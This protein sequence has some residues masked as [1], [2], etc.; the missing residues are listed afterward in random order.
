MQ[1]TKL[2]DSDVPEWA[3]PHMEGAARVT[4]PTTAAIV[5]AP[6][7][8]V[9]KDVKVQPLLSKM[10]TDAAVIQKQMSYQ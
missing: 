8:L 3:R 4:S 9:E 6:I 5:D 7:E 2:E 1:L 10:L